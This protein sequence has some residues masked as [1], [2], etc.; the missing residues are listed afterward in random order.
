MK[1]YEDVEAC[2]SIDT[3]LLGII[4]N[5]YHDPNPLV[6]LQSGVKATLKI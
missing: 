5:Q 6:K 2:R 4:V 1:M 3:D